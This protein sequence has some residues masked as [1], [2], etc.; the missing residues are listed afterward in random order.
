VKDLN[1]I[2]SLATPIGTGALSI[3]RCSGKGVKN[4]IET[5]FLKSLTPRYAYHIDFKK[6]NETLD[7]IVAIYYKAPES[8]TGEDMLEITCHGGPVIYQML[9]KE[10]LTLSDFRLAMPGEFSERAYLNNKISLL[11]AESICALINAKTEE[12]ALAARSSL[13]G[14]MSQ[15]ILSIDEKLLKIRIQVEALLD[16][17]EED[18][19]TAELYEIE[20]Q[21]IDIK[22]KIKNLIEKT[23]K[24]KLFFELSK[25]TIMGKPNTGKSS[26]INFLTQENV[27]IVNK[28]AGTTRDVVSKI[29]NIRG[30]PVIIQDTAG[31]RETDNQIEQEGT[32]K[33]FDQAAESNVIL[34]LYDVSK[35]LQKDDFLIIDKLKKINTNLL[36]IGNKVDLTVKNLNSLLRDQKEASISI[37]IKRNINIEKMIEKISDILL[38]TNTNDSSPGVMQIKHLAF[39]KTS[40]NE[41]NSIKLDLSNLEVVAEFLKAAQQNLSKIIENDDNDRVLS[42]IF[43]NFCIG[44]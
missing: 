26:L 13:S 41:I 18:I 8:Y 43:S 10:I 15:E 38:K 16:F 24:N 17:S 20:N 25:I 32:H 1:S 11:E 22:N 42:G 21:L 29:F 14:K 37:S 33:A 2:V 9:I 27:S 30:I 4:I 39:L 12:A 31:I 3:I 44:K 35:G 34:Y 7:D 19:E 28:E 6:N 36:I 5:F 40:F 23:E